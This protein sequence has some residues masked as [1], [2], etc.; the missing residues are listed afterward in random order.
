[1]SKDLEK[2]GTRGVR[3]QREHDE[4]YAALVARG[5][6]MGGPITL[7]DLGRGLLG[8]EGRAVLLSLRTALKGAGIPCDDDTTVE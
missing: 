5:R 4:T 3:E 7:G 6:R 8:E 2:G 1:M